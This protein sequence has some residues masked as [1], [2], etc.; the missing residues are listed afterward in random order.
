MPKAA[1]VATDFIKMTAVVFIPPNLPN[2]GDL[3]VRCQ[4]YIL[5]RGYHLIAFSRDWDE[6]EWLLGTGRAV[7]VIFA[8]PHHIERPVPAEI[9]SD[10]PTRRI[11]ASSRRPDQQTVVK[12][13]GRCPLPRRSSVDKAVILVPP[14][15]LDPHGARCTQVAEQEH[16]EIVGVVQDLAAAVRMMADGDA[17][18]LIVGHDDHLRCQDLRIEIVA[19]RP[20]PSGAR[21]SKIIRRSGRAAE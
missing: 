7:I 17:S 15:Q 16:L 20:T 11:R 4:A 18:V 6:V 21:R 10:E 19:L 3:A 1:D 13:I 9:A 8:D 14:G 12:A 5:R 2:D